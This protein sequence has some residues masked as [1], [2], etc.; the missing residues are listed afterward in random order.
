MVGKKTEDDFKD[1][2]FEVL[3]SRKVRQNKFRFK[4]YGF[5]HRLHV[6]YEL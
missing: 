3:L 6:T 1:S 5:C 4:G 2:L